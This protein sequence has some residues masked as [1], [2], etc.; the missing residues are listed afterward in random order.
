MIR[1][2]TGYGQGVAERPGFRV[3]VELRGLNNRFADLKLR[4]PPELLPREG[5]IRSR[6]LERVRRGRVEM[7][8]RLDGSPSGSALVLNRAVVD[9]V[10]AAART[11][12]EDWGVPGDLDVR[13]I[14]TVPGALQTASSAP[15]LH[16]DELQVVFEA[17]GGALAALDA[18][19]RREG[20][21]LRDDL[22]RRIE[23][24][25]SIVR[26]L[27]ECAARLP[28]LVRQ[29]LIDRLKTLAEG[30]E[31]DPTRLAQEAAFLADRSDVTE[32]IVRLEGHLAQADR[33][34]R[35]E[36]GEPVG[37]RLDFLLQEV[38]RETNTV[39]SKSADLEVTRHALAL[40]AETEKVREQVQ[41]LE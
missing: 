16:E 15:S 1:S 4:I 21:L 34:L 5:E 22:V 31:I 18:E 20:E 2:M 40:K 17:L 29:K 38:H 9:A 36:D 41:N 19:R 8:L 23:R 11:L 13:S 24:M 25:G 6:I 35:E 12:R 3:R 26:A 30:I 27:K 39:S 32:E 14:L 33:L 28:L 7:D 37:K 10:A